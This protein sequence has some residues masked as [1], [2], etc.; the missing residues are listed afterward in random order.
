MSRFIKHLAAVAAAV[1]VLPL[2]GQAPQSNAAKSNQE[3]I[4][5]A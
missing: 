4:L 3:I 2:Y 5:H 1:C